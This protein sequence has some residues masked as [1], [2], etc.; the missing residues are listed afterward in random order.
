MDDIEVRVT[1]RGSVKGE[2]MTTDAKLQAHC[3]ICARDVDLVVALNE[4]L[5]ACRACLRS[6]LDAASVATWRLAQPGK[7]P[8]LPWGKVA[9]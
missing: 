1:G 5:Y 7:A 6:R 9:G 3:G 8:G 2:A 4:N